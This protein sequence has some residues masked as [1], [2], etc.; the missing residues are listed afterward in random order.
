MPVY[1]KTIIS[2][3]VAATAAIA[4]YAGLDARAVVTGVAALMIVSI[5]LFPEARSRKG[6]TD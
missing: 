2:L 5:W 6:S 3:I 4:Y 1:L